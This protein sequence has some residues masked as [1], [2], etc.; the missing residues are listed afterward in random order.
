FLFP[1]L[2]CRGVAPAS[3]RRQCDLATAAGLLDVRYRVMGSEASRP[4]VPERGTRAGSPSS[5]VGRS[6]RDP[7]CSVCRFVPDAALGYCRHA[8][9]GTRSRLDY[10]LNQ[11]KKG[12]AVTE[13][14]IRQR[15]ADWANA[16]SAKNIDGI[17]SLYAPD[18][19]SFDLTPPLRYVGAD[20]KHRAWQEIFA[21]LSGPI[22]YE[23]RDLNVTTNG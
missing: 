23:I 6:D 13:M 15:V 21:S 10:A 17:A 5:R 19:V 16:I 2:W 9:A 14:L 1:I 18:L 22:D 7:P 20:G 8:R 11:R 12:R 3:R 4:S